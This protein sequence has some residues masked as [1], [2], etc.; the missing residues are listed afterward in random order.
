M[1]RNVTERA[2]ISLIEVM[3]AL[4]LTGFVVTAA[5]LLLGTLRDADVRITEAAARITVRATDQRALRELVAMM[6]TPSESGRRI[7]GDEGGVSFDS[8]CAT[9]GGW[10]EPCRVDLSVLALDP[11]SAVSLQVSGGHESILIH[12]PHRLALRYLSVIEES[13]QW[14]DE[15]RDNLSAP[16]A[17]ALLSTSDTL[18]LTAVRR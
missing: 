14:Q 8:W 16:Q 11:G 12:V 13:P 7:F 17:I 2:G 1:C 3:A 4:V 9:G 15:W 10:L 18:V 5:H 6:R